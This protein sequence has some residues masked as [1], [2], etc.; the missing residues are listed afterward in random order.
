MSKPRPLPP[1]PVLGQRPCAPHT[2]NTAPP[3]TGWRWY[4]AS[5]S[6]EP[7]CPA[8]AGPGGPA[9]AIRRGTYV[10]D[11]LAVDREAPE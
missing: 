7:V 9:T 11:G 6:W 3:A 2:R 8:C 5:R 4:R 1:P 10:P